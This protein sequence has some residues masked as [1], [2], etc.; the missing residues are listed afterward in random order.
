[1]TTKSRSWQKIAVS[2]HCIHHKI[3]LM[4]LLEI[5]V[6]TL[7]RWAFLIQLYLVLEDRS[8]S[9]AIPFWQLGIEPGSTVACAG[10]ADEAVM[11]VGNSRFCLGFTLYLILHNVLFFT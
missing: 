8:L 4:M 9:D 2:I 11:N 3:V 10:A 5:S 1:M 6:I 7:R